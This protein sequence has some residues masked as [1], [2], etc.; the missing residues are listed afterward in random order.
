M[1]SLIKRVVA[2][3][4]AL[5]PLHWR[6]EAGGR[7]R[8]TIDAVK[9]ALPPD[10][11][12]GAVV[13]GISRVVVG[14]ASR[15]H[16]DAMLKYA[17]EENVRIETALAKET[18]DAKVRQE[19]AKAS[20]MESRAQLAKIEE[21]HARLRLFDRLRERGVVVRWD[22]KGNLQ[23]FKAPPGFDWAKVDDL[24]LS[25]EVPRLEP[26]DDVSQE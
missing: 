13:E 3:V 1:S 12:P 9:E 6:G 26:G 20:T 11:V 2:K 15:D 18:A 5:L 16:S 23:V 8:H 17:E 7:F 24:I 10:E 25:E 19:R 14:L 4:R 21:I 22:S